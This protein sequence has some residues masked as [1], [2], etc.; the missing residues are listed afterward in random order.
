MLIFQVDSESASEETKASPWT[1]TGPQNIVKLQP[2]LA[3]AA[4]LPSGADLPSCTGRIFVVLLT[5]RAATS[6]KY[7]IYV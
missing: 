5:S 4:Q 2:S 1:Q 7:F 6:Y 3:L